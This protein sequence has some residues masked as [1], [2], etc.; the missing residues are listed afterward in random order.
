MVRAPAFVGTFPN[1]EPVGGYFANRGQRPVT[2][3][4]ECQ[5]RLWIERRRI[6]SAPIGT[7][8]CRDRARDAG[9]A[10]GVQ[11]GENRALRSEDQRAA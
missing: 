5:F 4:T 7:V 8:A 3:A 11:F 1:H 10:D 2:V 6:T 9:F